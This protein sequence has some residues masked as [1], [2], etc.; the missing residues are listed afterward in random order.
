M[1]DEINIVADESR[2]L[3]G[4]SIVQISC[5]LANKAGVTPKLEQ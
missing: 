1:I 4:E 2:E 3:E 5:I